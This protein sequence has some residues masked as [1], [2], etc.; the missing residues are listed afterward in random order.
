RRVGCVRRVVGMAVGDRAE[1]FE[2]AQVAARPALPGRV[3]A[4]E[5]P[6]RD[7]IALLGG[8]LQRAHGFRRIA[9]FHRL[10]AAVD[11]TRFDP[12]AFETERPAEAD[13][14]HQTRHAYGAINTP[15]STPSR[16]L[17]PDG[18]PRR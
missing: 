14:E 16:P 11:R 3:H 10:W 6:L 17:R 5:L 7:R 8:V 15:H 9:G 18:S 1:I 13:R 2:S 12:I 4:P